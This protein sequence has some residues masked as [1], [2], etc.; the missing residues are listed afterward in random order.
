[1]AAGEI[2]TLCTSVSWVILGA[3]LPASQ[4][5]IPLKPIPWSE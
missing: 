5:Q 4:T 2:E 3:Q 1:M